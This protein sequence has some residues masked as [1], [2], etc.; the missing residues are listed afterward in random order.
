[1]G[2]EMG[3]VGGIEPVG[4]IVVGGIIGWTI[5]KVIIK[6]IISWTK[7]YCKSVRF[8]KGRAKLLTRLKKFISNKTEEKESMGTNIKQQTD[9]IS[10]S[11]EGYKSLAQL[12]DSFCEYEKQIDSNINE[13]KGFKNSKYTL[14]EDKDKIDEYIREQEKM[15]DFITKERDKITEIAK[16]QAEKAFKKAQK[17]WND[18]A[19][20]ALG[21]LDGMIKGISAAQ[22]SSDTQSAI[23]QI[24]TNINECEAF[25]KDVALFPD[26]LQAVRE[27]LVKEKKGLREATITAQ[28]IK[29]VQQ[30]N[31]QNRV[32]NA[33][34]VKKLAQSSN[35][36]ELNAGAVSAI[37]RGDCNVLEY[38]IVVKKVSVQACDDIGNTLLHKA[39]SVNQPEIVKLLL[40]NGA[41][42]SAKNT[43]N[44]K[45]PLDLAAL[46]IK[47]LLEANN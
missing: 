39:V 21:R 18:K 6:P 2:R 25:E 34:R 1:M 10:S 41:D 47:R 28:V 29:D 46:E 15:K 40:K 35:M 5:Y 14:P 44:G 38:L 22:V 8:H 33:T 32:A 24:Q 17:S 23:E 3:L 19:Q 45:T 27:Q 30:S 11:E 16:K 31:P 26:V 42:K 13:L 4:V 20:K 36:T 9:S 7:D 37:R 43:R 12:V